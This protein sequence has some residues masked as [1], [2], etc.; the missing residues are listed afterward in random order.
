[1]AAQVDFTP[2]NGPMRV[3]PGGTQHWTQPHVALAE[4]PSSYL[5]STLVGCPAGAAIL[6]DVRTWHGGTPNVS[7]TARAIPNALFSPAWSPHIVGPVKRTDDGVEVVPQMPPEVY[8]QLGP[9]GQEIC[10]DML[11]MPEANL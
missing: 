7:D 9:K 10:R 2:L 8:A 1:M 4:E 3:I 5:W 11:K 6:R